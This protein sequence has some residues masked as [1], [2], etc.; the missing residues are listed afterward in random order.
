MQVCS[1]TRTSA[2]CTAD[3]QAELNPLLDILL[4]TDHLLNNDVS[5]QFTIHRYYQ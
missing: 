3:H 4:P 1:G 5:I 2:R